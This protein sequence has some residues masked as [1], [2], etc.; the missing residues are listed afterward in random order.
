[1]KY[2]P[3][4]VEELNFFSLR[5]SQLFLSGFAFGLDQFYRLEGDLVATFNFE[6]A[7]LLTLPGLGFFCRDQN[8][9][10]MGHPMPSRPGRVE[11]AFRE[12]S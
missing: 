12:N 8:R 7:L 3:K 11:Y 4:G 2:A 6:A 9:K 10:N 1:M 5:R